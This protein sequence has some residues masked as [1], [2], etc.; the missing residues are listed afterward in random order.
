MTKKNNASPTLQVSES[1]L[2]DLVR[3][4]L[5][6]RGPVNVLA[7][8]GPVNV[9]PVV[10]IDA[11]VSD[12]VN[13]SFV[14]QD[15]KELQAALPG[16]VKG[17]DKSD[18]PEVYRAIKDAIAS[19]TE[20]DDMKKEQTV[21]GIIRQNVK[22][23]VNKMIERKQRLNKVFEAA[24]P[25]DEDPPVEPHEYNTLYKKLYDAVVAMDDDALLDVLLVD[26]ESDAIMADAADALMAIAGGDP[27]AQKV[28]RRIPDAS[29]QDLDN[30]ASDYLDAIDAGGITPNPTPPSK[31]GADDTLYDKTP[32]DLNQLKTREKLEKEKIDKLHGTIATEMGTSP[33]SVVNI[34]RTGKVK[35]ILYYMWQ[36]DKN[37]G[38]MESFE[39]LAG[40]VSRDEM[41]MMGSREPA[42]ELG[43]STKIT[44]AALSGEPPKWLGEENRALF[45]RCKKGY[46]MFAAAVEMFQE[47]LSAAISKDEG[48]EY[49]L[50]DDD[51]IVFA[52]ETDPYTGGSNKYEHKL[53]SDEFD[54]IAKS[55][56]EKSSGKLS[57]R[58]KE[59]IEAYSKWQGLRSFLI[60]WGQDAD[61]MLDSVMRIYNVA[62]IENRRKLRA[63][64]DED[65]GRQPRGR[66]K[67]D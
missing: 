9:D 26:C 28:A 51:A 2:R 45:N 29:P 53:F 41:K 59:F 3:E 31:T 35:M 12:P 6:T 60:Y 13:P 38:D 56:L 19:S 62:S 5:D 24:M 44:A 48:R 63:Q 42:L 52:L 66:A 10:A 17:V 65:M 8:K 61:K 15:K 37:P 54:E 39:E 27:A 21:E 33:S 11:A 4:A 16:M 67:K 47:D 32:E 46:E 40:A 50:S 25:T 23:I 20:S 58:D 34:E 49:Q 7:P 22:Q 36:Y 18:V 30:I 1:A 57:K 14:P 64:E 43:W 55:Y